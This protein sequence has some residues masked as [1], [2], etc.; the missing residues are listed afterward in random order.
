VRLVHD[1][2]VRGVDWDSLDVGEDDIERFG[3]A[4]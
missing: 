1:E 2:S 3:I 4:T